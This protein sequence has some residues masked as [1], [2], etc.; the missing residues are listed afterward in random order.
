MQPHN[1]GDHNFDIQLMSTSEALYAEDGYYSGPIKLV[2]FLHRREDVS[3]DDF[4]AKYRAHGDVLVES[5]GRGLLRKYVQNAERRVTRS[6]TP[7]PFSSS[8]AS[9]HTL[10]TRS[11]GSTT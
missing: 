11:C 4:K 1:F 6:T 5:R 3:L 10:G 9:T 2:H 7:V 8:A